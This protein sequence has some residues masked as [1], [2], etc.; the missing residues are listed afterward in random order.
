MPGEEDRGS[1]LSFETSRS[2]QHLELLT[3]LKR[4]SRAFY[5]SIRVLP[6]PIRRP[7]ALAYLLA[8]AADTIADTAAISPDE[9]LA[10]L[11][12][13]R[14]TLASGQY[15]D[16]RICL[17]RSMTEYQ[18]TAI[19]RDLL[20]AIPGALYSLGKLHKDD[21]DLVTH[22]VIRLTEG[23][24]FDLTR[25]SPGQMEQVRSIASVRELDRYTY[26]VAGCVGEFWTKITAAHT[27]EL[28][29]WDL[30]RMS[31]IGVRFGQAL[32]MTNVLR[33]LPADVSAGRCYLPSDWL[34]EIGLTPHDLSDPRTRLAAR[35]ALARGV[36]MALEHFREAERYIMAIP[37]SCVRL[38]L[39]AIWPLLM[40]LATLEKVTRNPHWLN[41]N[42]RV[43]V[44]RV[45]VFW[46]IGASLLVG[47]SNWL[48]SMWIR[49][50]TRR[51][52]SELGRP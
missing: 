30:D 1:R 36:E 27:Q 7:V 33:D 32:Q 11:L 14:R 13:F 9:R 38:R 44:S 46:M 25:F 17:L 3:L 5:L 49:R 2:S 15:D 48:V 51:V 50:L 29:G 24:E 16:E 12:A 34:A 4:V 28:S 19:E 6:N 18:P 8:R 10:H 52:R 43:K 41:P 21:R 42:V 37:R 31:A 45:W 47:R 20:S 22:I 26:L 23:M 40:G 35:P 39:A